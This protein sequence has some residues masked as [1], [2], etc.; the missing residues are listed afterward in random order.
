MLRCIHAF[1]ISRH[2]AEL[3]TH[4]R[5]RKN[6]VIVFRKTHQFAIIANDVG[7]VGRVEIMQDGLAVAPH[8]ELRVA[9]RHRFGGILHLH[10]RRAIIGQWSQGFTSNLYVLTRMDSDLLATVDL[11]LPVACRFS[12]HRI[13][14]FS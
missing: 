6:I 5:I 8:G 9:F 1:E 11:Y 13:A 12:A 10:A 14:S 7:A 2:I 4:R 3:N